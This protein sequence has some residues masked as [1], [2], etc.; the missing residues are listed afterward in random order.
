MEQ[1]TP[2][3]SYYHGNK[4][5]AV[6]MLENS[7]VYSELLDHLKAKEAPPIICTHGQIKLAN[8]IL[9]DK[10]TQ[11]GTTV[12]YSGDFDPEGLLIAQRLLLR[13]GSRLKLWHYGLEDYR[14]SLSEVELED[15]R[16]NKLQGVLAPELA[17]VRDEMKKYKKA[18]YQEHFVER[19]VADMETYLR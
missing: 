9:L 12:Y 2:A 19:L 8:L 7:G 17:Q 3:I 14:C 10:L 6:F 4:E 15:S 16:I 11:N 5:K 1:F 18:A 13:Y